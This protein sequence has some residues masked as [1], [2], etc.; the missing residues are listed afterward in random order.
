MRNMLLTTIAATGVLSAAALIPSQA[1]ATPLGA[2]V[3][4]DDGVAAQP[5][6]WWG[7]PYGAYG[8]REIIIH[9]RFHERPFFRHRFERRWRGDG[10]D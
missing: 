8:D 3:V 5:V 2:A 6:T 10:D 9:R 4:V 7:G 1:G